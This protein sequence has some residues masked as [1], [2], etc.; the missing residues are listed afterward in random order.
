[1]DVVRRILTQ[2]PVEEGG[3]SG[4][5]MWRSA[6]EVHTVVGGEEDL[7]RCEWRPLENALLLFE[8]I[9]QIMGLPLPSFLCCLTG[10]CVGLEE[11]CKV[12]PGNV[13]AV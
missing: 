10:I 12:C 11:E 7:G 1:V 4:F 2:L 6:E 8:R 9:V 13:K 5:I 3:N